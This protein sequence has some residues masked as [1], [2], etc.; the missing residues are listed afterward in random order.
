M[1]IEKTKTMLKM[2]KR[3]TVSHPNISK[4]V[5]P[6]TT[7]NPTTRL[8]RSAASKKGIRKKTAP[9]FLPKSNK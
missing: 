6:R 8:S 1:Y 7:T 2:T 9:K 3:F 4:K 5:F